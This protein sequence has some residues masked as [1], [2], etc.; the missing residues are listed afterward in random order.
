MS[1][2]MYLCINCY[3]C[4]CVVFLQELRRRKRAADGI[5][6]TA[7]IG[8]SSEKCGPHT[9]VCNGP[10][11]PG[12]TYGVRYTLF[13]GDQF[14]AYD[15]FDQAQ[16]TTGEKMEEREGGRKRGRERERGRER[17]RERRSVCVHNMYLI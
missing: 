12:A 1:V 10:L 5:P 8:N 16:I 15:F 13:S 7:T 17:N 14:Q 11:D 9:L 2:Y 6:I 4:M 3:V